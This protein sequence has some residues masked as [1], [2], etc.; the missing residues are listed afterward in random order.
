MQEQRILYMCCYLYNPISI[1]TGLKNNVLYGLKIL[2]ITAISTKIKLFQDKLEKQKPC[3]LHTNHKVMLLLYHHV[4]LNRHQNILQDNQF[5]AFILHWHS[6]TLRQGRVISDQHY[7]V[8][9]QRRDTT[10]NSHR[11]TYLQQYNHGR[12]TNQYTI[13]SCHHRVMFLTSHTSLI[14]QDL[15]HRYLQLI[16][17]LWQ[18]LQPI[19]LV[20]SHK[21]PFVLVIWN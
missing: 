7:R 9:P 18:D 15:Q 11:G 13:M 17:T 12:I 2:K 16:L 8:I 19:H 4:L 10:Y 5:Q 21:S 14:S 6:L 20:L 1:I 3:V